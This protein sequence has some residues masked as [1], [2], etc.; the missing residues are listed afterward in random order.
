M[1]NLVQISLAGRRGARPR[2][3]T[4]RTV[5]R[6]LNKFGARLLLCLGLASASPAR[7]ADFFI[8]MDTSGSMRESVPSTAGQMRIKVLVK[9]ASDYIRALPNGSRLML[10]AFNE[11]LRSEE[12]VL[13]TEEDRR[14]AVAWVERLEDE[15]QH[16]RRTA[17]WGAMRQ[18]FRAATACAE[19]NPRQTVSVRVL[20]DG[21]DTVTGESPAQALP[22]LRREFPRVDGQSINAELVLFGM[23]DLSAFAWSG[24]SVQTN[25][26]LKHLFPP[27]I[28]WSPDPFEAGQPV[29]FFDA[30]TNAFE[31]YEWYVNDQPAGTSK[32]L[33]RDFSR[34][35]TGRIKLVGIAPSRR[36]AATVAVTP[37]DTEL[38]ADFIFTAGDIRP[39]MAVNLFGRASGR[40]TSWEW[41]VNGNLCARGQ[42]CAIKFPAVGKYQV[43]LA[44]TDATG[45][46]AE[47]SRW[48]EVHDTRVNVG[49]RF[50]PEAPSSG[51]AVQ[52]ISE[53]S[54]LKAKVRWSFGDGGTSTDPHPSHVYCLPESE[55]RSF[56]VLLTV[57]TEEKRMFTAR[58]VVSVLPEPLKVGIRAPGAS[59]V[60][61][62]TLQLA[63]EVTGQPMRFEWTSDDGWTSNERHPSRLFVLSGNQAREVKIILR[64][65]SASGRTATA[66][67]SILVL[68]EKKFA[69]PIAR[70]RAFGGGEHKAGL[71]VEFI[72]ESTNAVESY[73]W[74]FNEEGRSTAKNPSF[75][76]VSSGPKRVRLV[77][78]GPGGSAT[79]ELAL[80]I[81]PRYTAPGIIRVIADKTQGTVPLTVNFRATATGDFTKARWSFGDGLTAFGT[82][83][84]HT[85]TNPSSYQVLLVLEPSDRNHR[86]PQAGLLVEA[87][88]AS[89]SWPVP[90]AAGALALAGLAGLARK[91]R[92]R[93]LFGTLWCELRGQ[94]TPVSLTGKELCLNALNLPA[95][96]P[97]QE[98]II[99]NRGTIHVCGQDGSKRDLPSLRDTP[100]NLDGLALQIDTDN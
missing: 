12:T 88:P 26:T 61:G 76:F 83:T 92:L 1:K 72:D 84:T 25:T 97:A 52:F 23:F 22:Q 15:T 29:A 36:L 68:P 3:L 19:Q 55:A 90:A 79:N 6:G 11:G 39:D 64:V 2:G 37:S 18:A 98:Y 42:D 80:R 71:P 28:A 9:A 48:L 58:R 94:K 45:H 10:M 91:R 5:I 49:F 34:G 99:R 53:V 46:R 69:A 65:H 60:S 51:A 30:S 96:N 62:Q 27:V 75:V 66:T 47:A 24:L 70:F 17:L 31:A 95:W 40:P 82:N 20:S 74:D 32:T 16:G 81:V 41:F 4:R 73:S 13:R 57:T 93:P 86:C 54:D 8:L 77:V 50:V 14:R 35:E 56:E 59:V 33:I 78:R 89:M 7:G 85:F 21:L 87:Y 67:K 44:V 38:T 100:L 63:S 43:V